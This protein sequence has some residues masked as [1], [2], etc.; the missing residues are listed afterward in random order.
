MNAQPHDDGAVGRV[1]AYLDIREQWAE[2]WGETEKLAIPI[3]VQPRR[4]LEG[5]S[6]L[7]L[8]HADLRAVLRELDD[9]KIEA[10]EQRNLAEN[11]YADTVKALQGWDQ[12]LLER[13]KARGEVERLA[14]QHEARDGD[15][16]VGHEWATR[17]P[18][19]TRTRW[20]REWQ[21]RRFARHHPHIKV[22]HRE[23][24]HFVGDWLETAGPPWHDEDAEPDL[25]NEPIGEID[26]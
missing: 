24:R 10:F 14:R 1:T 26:V 16:A 25:S 21:A 23:I 7:Q 22:D 11:S 2:F 19:G 3:A 17:T 8:T 18:D 6:W 15:E 12:A 13:D 5:P 4:G 9:A 20:D